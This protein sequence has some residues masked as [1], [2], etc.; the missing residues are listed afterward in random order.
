MRFKENYTR[1]TTLMDLSDPTLY[2]LSKPG[3]E[4]AV[5]YYEL[6]MGVFDL[7]PGTK[8][9]YLE[10]AD[11]LKIMDSHLFLADQTRFEMMR[12][13]GWIVE[14]AAQRV[15]ILELVKNQETVKII[16]KKHPPMLAAEH[17]DFQHFKPL[18]AR[19]KEAFVRRL[20]PKALEEFMHRFE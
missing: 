4:S 15:S 16:C 19:D 14:Y 11:Q 7:G 5:A 17:P 20:L 13:L 6:I 2:F 9:Y 3:E 18:I 12:R 10:K 1:S 8:F